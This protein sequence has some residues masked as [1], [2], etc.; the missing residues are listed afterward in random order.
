MT[1]S[2]PLPL[3]LGQGLPPFETITPE[4]VGQ[5]IPGLLGELN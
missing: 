1:L 2:A 4:Q 3:L 5:A